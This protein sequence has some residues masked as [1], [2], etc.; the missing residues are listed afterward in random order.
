MQKQRLGLRLADLAAELV[1]LKVD[2]IVV[3]VTDALHAAKQATATIPIVTLTPADPVALGHVAGL[4]R[5]DGNITGVGS[6]V[7]QLRGKLLGVLKGAVP[8]VTKVA[9]L[10]PRQG[11]T[12]R[13]LRETAG[14]AES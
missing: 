13:L 14:A 8:E 10:A 1:R 12:K 6:Q 11:D 2:V 3:R 4:T 5:P 9:V 7:Q